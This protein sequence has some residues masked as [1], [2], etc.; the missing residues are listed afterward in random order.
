MHAHSKTDYKIQ[1]GEPISPPIIACDASMTSGL[2]QKAL[3]GLRATYSILPNRSRPQSSFVT[4]RCY[5]DY[6]KN[7]YSDCL[8]QPGEQI[9]SSIIVCD[10]STT[11]GLFQKALIGP[12]IPSWRT[13]LVWNHRLWHL[14]V[15]G[16][17]PKTFNRT[18]YSILASRS[19][20]QS[21]FVTPRWYRDYSKNL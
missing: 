3:I 7:L 19:R 8:F 18:T 15:T 9:S 17:I 16:T 2:F 20:S 13:D 5:R 4:S 10:T 12:L 1:P 14:D 11:S 21:S 6:S